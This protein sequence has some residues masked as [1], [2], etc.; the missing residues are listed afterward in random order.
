MLRVSKAA[1]NM[2]AKW[3]FTANRCGSQ[4]YSHIQEITPGKKIKIVLH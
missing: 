3:S 2:K 4:K 1:G